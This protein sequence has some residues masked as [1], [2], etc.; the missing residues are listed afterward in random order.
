MVKHDLKEVSHS[1]H[2]LTKQHLYIKY[3]SGRIAKN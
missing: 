3:V 1:K 2:S